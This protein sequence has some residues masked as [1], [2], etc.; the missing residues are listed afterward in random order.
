M[1]ARRE[2]SRHELRQKLTQKYRAEV[3]AELI[4]T[5][6]DDLEAANLV[7]DQRFAE[8]LVRSRIAKGYGPGYIQQE[9]ASKGV[10]DTLIE[11]ELQELDINWLQ[12]ACDLVA[13]RHADHGASQQAWQKAARFLQRRGY[14]SEVVRRALGNVPY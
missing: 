4:I 10:N 6:L 11:S 2:Y 1:L 5:V 14:P 7:S 3:S 9:L 8:M 12:Q 13:R